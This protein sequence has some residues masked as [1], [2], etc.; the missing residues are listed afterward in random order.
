MAP[1]TS[2]PIAATAWASV[3]GRAGAYFYLDRGADTAEAL[4]AAGQGAI[5]STTAGPGPRV[6]GYFESGLPAAVNFASSAA[7]R[8]LASAGLT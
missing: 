4:R 5:Y 6:Q 2:P 7:F 8:V 1:F 3:A